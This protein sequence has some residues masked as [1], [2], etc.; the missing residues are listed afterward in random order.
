MEITAWMS[1]SEEARHHI[2]IAK[3]AG[4][5]LDAAMTFAM[6]AY[7]AMVAETLST[8]TTYIGHPITTMAHIV[9]NASMNLS[10]IVMVAGKVTLST[11]YTPPMMVNFIAEAALRNNHKVRDLG[12]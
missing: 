12:C 4:R 5:A 7:S 3:R 2:R 11:T 10:P 8:T 6:I 1:V 9:I